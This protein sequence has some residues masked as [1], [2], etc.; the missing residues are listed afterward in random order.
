ME[1]VINFIKIM[2]KSLLLNE[3]VMCICGAYSLFEDR[4]GKQVKIKPPSDWIKIDSIDDIKHNMKVKQV[5]VYENYMQTITN[6][7]QKMLNDN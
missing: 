6:R 3:Y 7:M 1:E 2:R 5:F 4:L